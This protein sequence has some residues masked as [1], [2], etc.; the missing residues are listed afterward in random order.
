MYDV[1]I[2]HVLFQLLCLFRINLYISGLIHARSSLFS[3][4]LFV[5]P[6]K[7][8]RKPYSKSTKFR[9]FFFLQIFKVEP[10]LRD[11]LLSR[12]R[13]SQSLLFSK[14]IKMAHENAGKEMMVG[15]SNSTS[16]KNTGT[17]NNNDLIQWF[18][19]KRNRNGRSGP[20]LHMLFDKRIETCFPSSW[21]RID[22]YWRW[23]TNRYKSFE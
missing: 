8:Y 11:Q 10:I 12:K 18:A 16:M 13:V 1:R 22:L 23:H 5:S 17:S 4:R 20:C 7:I 15:I 6:C 2:L 21:C 9:A 14:K 19:Q 3:T